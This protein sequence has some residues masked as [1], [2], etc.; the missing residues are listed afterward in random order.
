LDNK[1][2]AI[3]DVAGSGKSPF[4]LFRLSSVFFLRFL[5]VSGFLVLILSF[6]YGIFN[7]TMLD[8]SR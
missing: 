1:T 5:R 7:A 2:I 3:R 8:L 6:G 4:E